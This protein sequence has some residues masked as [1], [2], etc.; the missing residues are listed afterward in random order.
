M[1]LEV[2]MMVSAL[3]IDYRYLLL[4]IYYLLFIIYYFFQSH[5]IV[6]ARSGHYHIYNYYMRIYIQSYII[7]IT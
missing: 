2:L 5:K 3:H 6:I 4:I 7:Y 1:D